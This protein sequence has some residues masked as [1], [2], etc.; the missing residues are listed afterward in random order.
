MPHQPG[1]KCDC[2]TMYCVKCRKKT[3][4]VNLVAH[5]D[6]RGKIMKTGTCAECGTKVHKYGKPC[7]GFK[8]KIAYE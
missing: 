5:T 1:E 8:G 2:G 4:A 3:K 7:C 6:S